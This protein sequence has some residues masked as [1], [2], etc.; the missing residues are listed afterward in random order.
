MLCKHEHKDAHVLYMLIDTQVTY[1][2]KR[3]KQY[4]EDLTNVYGKSLSRK[5]LII[6]QQDLH[7]KSHSATIN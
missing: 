4:K 3:V 5:H 7:V 1:R 6:F 2:K